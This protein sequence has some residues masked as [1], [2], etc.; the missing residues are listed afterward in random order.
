MCHAI[1]TMQYTHLVLAGFRR[2][3]NSNLTLLPCSHTHTGSSDDV[4]HDRRQGARESQSQCP[5]SGIENALRVW[6]L[7]KKRN[8]PVPM[9][10]MGR[11]CSMQQ[12]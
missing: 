6:V 2:M 3:S 7:C 11:K 4:T 12:P 1:V 9:A 8:P 10:F 5:L